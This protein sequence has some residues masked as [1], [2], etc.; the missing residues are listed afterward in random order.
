MLADDLILFEEY[1]LFPTMTETI[2]EIINP[3]R[4]ITIGKKK[5]VKIKSLNKAR[6]TGEPLYIIDG[7]AT[8][9]TDFFLSLKT[10]DLIF[11]KIFRNSKKLARLGFIGK[12]GIV[13]V[14]TKLGN[15]REPLNKSNL[16]TGL[17]MPV[18]FSAPNYDKGVKSLIPDFRSTIFWAPS[19]STDANGNAQV[20]F[21]TSDDVGSLEIRIDGFSKNGE[22]FTAFRTI[23]VVN[24][25][26]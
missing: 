8:K 7:I 3:L 20:A 9:N 5:E 18:R 6:A 23:E 10:S 11:I 12:N 13:M 22:P 17:Q 21:Y 26:N 14:Q 4:T 15:A 19:I 25:S 24:G 2:K 16:I 1:K